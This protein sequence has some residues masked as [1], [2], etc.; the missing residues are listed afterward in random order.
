[1]LVLHFNEYEYYDEQENKICEFPA[2]D[3]YLEHSLS[4]VSAWE[5]KWKVSFLS[6]K[7]EKTLEQTIDYVRCMVIGEIPDPTVFDR[8]TSSHIKEVEAYINDK[9]SATKIN[10]RESKRV[11][12]EIITAEVIYFWM[13][14]AGIPFECDKWH[15]SKLLT[16]IEVCAAK[17]GPAKKMSMKEQMAQQRA[18]NA[19]RCSKYHTRG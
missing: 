8:I 11:A 12:N 13:I 16:L 1:V 15:L 6:D 18:L 2:Q 14:Q 17:S 4:S 19:A 5:S 3:L 7:K 10:H 9:M